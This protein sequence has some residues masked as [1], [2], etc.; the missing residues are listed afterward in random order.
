MASPCLRPGLEDRCPEEP[1]GTQGRWAQLWEWT[2][3]WAISMVTPWATQAWLGGQE[4]GPLEGGLCPGLGLTPCP[5][6]VLL[7]FSPTSFSCPDEP[8]T[9]LPLCQT[10][11]S[12]PTESSCPIL[13]MKESDTPGSGPPPQSDCSPS[14]PSAPPE[15]SSLMAAQP[16]TMLLL[17]VGLLPSSLHQSCLTCP[18]KSS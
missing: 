5:S 8:F 10:P 11:H 14:T 2:A 15:Y 13:D 12:R 18:P 6:P 9:E 3:G 16:L 17:L 7:P 4:P 1:L